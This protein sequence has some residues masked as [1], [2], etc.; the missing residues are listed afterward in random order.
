MGFFK[1]K[2]ADELILPPP[3][4][5]PDFDEQNA[6]PNPSPLPTHEDDEI[7]AAIE[8]LKA[9]EEKKKGSFFS[10][11]FKPKPKAEI[12][13]EPNFMPK[14]ETS[15]IGT[16]N[17]LMRSARNHL[18]DLKLGE[19]KKDYIAIMKIYNQLKPDEQKMAYEDIKE[20]YD[21]RKNAEALNLH[22]K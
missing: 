8:K 22:V 7:T 2:K 12:K 17:N 3:P 19:A 11:L 18:L 15:N 21:E 10:K 6:R 4:P 1:K 9:E 16:I 13:K 20:L 5:L 14:P